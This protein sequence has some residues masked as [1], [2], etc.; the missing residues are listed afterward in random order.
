MKT[1]RMQSRW[2]VLTAVTLVAAL[3]AGCVPSAT[4][5]TDFVRDF[6]L[7]ATAAFLL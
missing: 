2:T 4:E 3:S 1:R 5:W 7:N 6:A